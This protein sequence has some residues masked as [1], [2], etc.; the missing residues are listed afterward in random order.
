MA[1]RFTPQF[2]ERFYMNPRTRVTTRAEMERRAEAVGAIVKQLEI[3][4]AR[5][6]DVGCGLGWMRAG[7]LAAFPRAKYVGLEVSEHLCAQ[8][9][10][11]NASIASYQPRGAFDLVICYDVFQYLSDAEARRAFANIA[12]FCRGALYFHAPTTEDWKH[13]AD[14]TC[15]DAAIRLRPA[16]WYRARLERSFKHAGLGVYVR[17]GVP[18]HQWELEKAR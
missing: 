11:V 15:S 3:K 12:R 8:Y 1:H 10:W 13:N 6:L 18:L 5:I 7:L 4:V 17:R 9:G 2:Y 16:G 14:R